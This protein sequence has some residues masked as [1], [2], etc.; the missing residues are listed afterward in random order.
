MSFNPYEDNIAIT[1][2]EFTLKKHSDFIF[3]Q[4]NE[5]YIVSLAI[6]SHG[7]A[8]PQIDFNFMPFPKVRVGNTVR[9]LG[10]GHL[11]YCPKNPGEFVALSLLVMESDNDLRDFGKELETIVKSKAVSIG[12]SAIISSNPGSGAILGILKELA[13]LISGLLK[14]NKDDELFRLDGTFL[15][16]H[17]V[18][19]HINRKYTDYGNDYINMAIQIIPLSETNGQGVPVK[20]IPLP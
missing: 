10:D 1:I 19:Y 18:S 4:Y 11:V 16:D 7:A 3:Q 2:P 15:R 6:D 14:Q 17:P 8:N 12:I 9:M 20:T 5:P 13:V